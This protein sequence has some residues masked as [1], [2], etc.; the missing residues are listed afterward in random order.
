M[1]KVSIFCIGFLFI[2]TS[3]LFGYDW[4]TPQT[5]NVSLSS[6]VPIDLYADYSGKHIVLANSGIKYYLVSRD[7]TIIRN[8]TINGSG[9]NPQI[10]GYDAK[11]FVFYKVSGILYAKKSS[12]AGQ[13]WMSI[14]YLASVNQYH[15]FADDKGVHLVYSNS[16]DELIYKRYDY[17]EENWQ[18]TQSLTVPLLPRYPFVTASASIVH[19]AHGEWRF[20]GGVNLQEKINASW[21]TMEEVVEHGDYPV[22][23]ADN[24]SLHCFYYESFGEGRNNYVIYHTYRDLDGGEWET[25]YEI[26]DVAP[27]PEYNE[28]LLEAVATVNDTVHIIYE[29]NYRNFKDGTWSSET[30]YGSNGSK[31]EQLAAN[32][33]DIFAAWVVAD[34]E[35]Y[36]LKIRQKDYDPLAPTNLEWSDTQNNHPKISWDYTNCDIDEYDV[37]RAM[38][39][40]APLSWSKIT[41]TSNAYYVDTDITVSTGGVGP[42]Y[43]NYKV[44][45]RDYYDHE[46]PFSDSLQI[47][48]MIPN[49]SGSIKSIALSGSLIPSRVELYRNYPNPFNPTTKINF[50]LPEDQNVQLTIYSIT[51]E[52][53]ATLADG[54]M[55]KG[56]HQV[57]WNGTNQTGSPVSSGVYIYELATDDMRLTRKMLLA[58]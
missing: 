18:D 48:Y 2:L 1:R 4:L 14:D 52:K 23:V 37:Y 28:H 42:Y 47:E 7:G 6:A 35:S 16:S 33:N 20:T 8:S 15:I 55:E 39:N 54:F 24:E 29:E 32:G 19:V 45:A 56:F 49:G 57:Q 5:I 51:G 46:S 31:H 38:G 44:L 41:T 43:A 21:Q 11:I 25:A 58:K 22:L 27:E 34:G 36:L 26:E 40:E 17:G 9:D 53:A 50:S 10:T 13:N 3:F 30:T 12:D